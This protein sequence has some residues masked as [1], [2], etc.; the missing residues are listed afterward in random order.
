M[1]SLNRIRSTVFLCIL[2]VL[3]TSGQT[4]ENIPTEDTVNCSRVLGSFVPKADRV[5]KDRG[6]HCI[7]LV[8]FYTRYTPEMVCLPPHGKCYMKFFE[9]HTHDEAEEACARYGGM[10]VR[11]ESDEESATL[12]KLADGD[13]H[14]S[15]KRV[16]EDERYDFPEDMPVY[17]YVALLFLFVFRAE[18]GFASVTPIG[19]YVWP[20]RQR[21]D[22][23]DRSIAQG[24]LS[25]YANFKPCTWPPVFS[26]AR[27][28]A[29]D[30]LRAA[31]EEFDRLLTA[32]TIRASDSSS[33][34]PLHMV[35]KKDSAV[36]RP[37]GDYRALNS[38]TTPDRC[39]IPHIH[40]F[41]A[42][43]YGNTIF[44]KL[45]LLRAY[46]QVPVDSDDIPKTA[47]ITPFGL[48][49]FL[50]MP[51]WREKCFSNLPTLH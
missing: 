21:K 11:P 4:S 49:D 40:D 2:F 42:C 19:V 12:A 14:L 23:G 45:P 25:L 39:P 9:N 41:T 1:W 8:L 30:K 17:A 22:C 47:V 20:L 24:V 28:H 26:R 34:S 3:Y 32:G 15:G 13:F 37:C 6:N 51:F 27:R 31:K 18:I 36:W 48:F 33:A 46:Y 10:I 7:S 43:L 5:N 29:P 16:S 50:R 44:S 35:P 38:V